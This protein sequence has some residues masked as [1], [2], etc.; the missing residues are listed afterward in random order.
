MVGL[1][2]EHRRIGIAPVGVRRCDCSSRECAE[3]KIERFVSVLQNP[4]E[5]RATNVAALKLVVHFVGDLH[6]PL[7]DE[8]N[9]SRGGKTREVLFDNHTDDLHWLGDSLLL[10]HINRNSQVLVEELD[11]RQQRRTWLNWNEGACYND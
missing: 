1:S 8:D 10:Q 6:Q 11:S 2:A 3:V 9:G 5:R 4:E 7:H